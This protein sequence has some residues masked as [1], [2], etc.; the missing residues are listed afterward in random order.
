MGICMDADDQEA[1]T[2]SSIHLRQK[3]PTRTYCEPLLYQ[4]SK[5][6]FLSGDLKRN[7]NEKLKLEAQ[8]LSKYFMKDL[9]TD[10][11]TSHEII[12]EDD[13]KIDLL[14]GN[15]NCAYTLNPENNKIYFIVNNLTIMTLDLN[16]NKLR[17]LNKQ[18]SFKSMDGKLK[19]NTAKIV[20]NNGKLYVLGP[21][22]ITNNNNEEKEDHGEL[23]TVPFS[24]SQEEKPRA[25]AKDV[26]YYKINEFGALTRTI[27]ARFGD[28]DCIFM[29]GGQ[30]LKEDAL[31]P[32][33]DIFIA[34]ASNGKWQNF[35]H[36]GDEHRK[37]G[38]LSCGNDGLQKYHTAYPTHSFGI[39]NYKNQYLFQFGGIEYSK[40][41]KAERKKEA[42][43]YASC[44]IRVFPIAPRKSTGENECERFVWYRFQSITLP[45]NQKGFM[46]AIYAENHNKGA[47]IELFN[48][49]GKHISFPIAL[50]LDAI[51]KGPRVNYDGI[52]DM[53]R[54]WTEY[55]KTVNPTKST[56]I[57][58]LGPAMDSEVD[59]MLR[60]LGEPYEDFIN[61]V[62][63]FIEYHEVYDE[64]NLKQLQTVITIES[65][66]EVI[67]AEAKRL[68][69]LKQQKRGKNEII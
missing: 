42:E 19:N 14:P 9:N 10:Q 46:H 49:F 7:A 21:D 54:P 2:E 44:E 37:K 45:F 3:L 53:N 15:N 36:I 59:E 11:V 58:N 24:K 38:N 22:D 65:Y 30:R 39:I 6:I 34:S 69:K 68:D 35:T 27:N 31:L 52:S 55:P 60:D 29:M 64:K 57:R 67:I 33:A 63:D 41:V 48:Y 4:N 26:K 20:Y 40:S 1:P 18:I 23:I 56:S 5:I 17:S 43:R 13:I 8:Y 28:K 16:T 25:Q 51:K 47:Y 32:H 61:C 62:D 66:L 50:L 12:F